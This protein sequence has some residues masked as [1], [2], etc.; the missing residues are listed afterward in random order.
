METLVYTVHAKPG[1]DLRAVGDRFSLMAMLVPPLWPLVH[2][3]WLTLA[4]LLAVL[5]LAF[6]WSPFAVSPVIYG[7]A[8]ILA[9]EG[10]AVERTELRLRGWREVGVVEART[11]EGAEEL[12]LRGEAA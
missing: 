9:F 11:P 4:G 6:L 12:Y 1:R 10:G 7:I 8:V 2:G 3:L 5:V